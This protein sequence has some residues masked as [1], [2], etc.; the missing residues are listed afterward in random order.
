M[1]CTVPP[2]KPAVACVNRYAQRPRWR[3]EAGRTPSIVAIPALNAAVCPPGTAVQH[4]QD[5]D[6][7]LTL[8]ISLLGLVG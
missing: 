7:R 4:I 2:P 3:S 5:F 1:P 6:Q 8:G